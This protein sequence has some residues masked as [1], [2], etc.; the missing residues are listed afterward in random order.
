MVTLGRMLAFVVLVYIAVSVCMVSIYLGLSATTSNAFP[1][2]FLLNVVLP[3]VAAVVV[4]FLLIS[5][6]LCESKWIKIRFRR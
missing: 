3:L 5:Y 6:A 1:D 4:S 2:N